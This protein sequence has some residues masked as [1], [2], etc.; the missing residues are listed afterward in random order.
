MGVIVGLNAGTESLVAVMG[1]ILVIAVADAMSDAL[2]IHIAQEADSE[3]SEKQVWS[4]TFA[5]FF[6]K[7]LTALS[8]ALPF[9]LLSF[10]IAI[11]IS[12]IWGYVIISLLSY[13]L[14]SA[15]G[16]KPLNVIVEHVVIATLVIAASH[17]IGVWV[18][19]AFS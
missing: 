4:A 18:K 16:I 13:K 9:V 6:A 17:A 3:T 2:G 5:T 19:A 10:G 11:L 12:V 8:F 7:F 14:A 15:Q 1:G